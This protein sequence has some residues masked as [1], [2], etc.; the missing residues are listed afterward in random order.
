MNQPLLHPEHYSQTPVPTIASSRDSG[1]DCSTSV[2]IEAAADK[3]SWRPLA[4]A[5]STPS[6]SSTVGSHSSAVESHSSAVESHSSA[7]ESHSSAVGSHSSA[8]E[9]HSSAAGSHSSAESHSMDAARRFSPQ[10]SASH[11]DPAAGGLSS[12]TGNPSASSSKDYGVSQPIPKEDQWRRYLDPATN[13]FYWNDGRESV[14]LFHVVLQDR[15]SAYRRFFYV[16]ERSREKETPSEYISG[17]F[18][19]ARVPRA[20]HFA[21]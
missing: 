3:G 13:R 7:V 20:F 1:S 17:M 5:P 2:G 9:S 4:D 14:S 8:V 16:V 19:V 6:Y 21:A 10:C 18:L 11:Q 15:D 12:R